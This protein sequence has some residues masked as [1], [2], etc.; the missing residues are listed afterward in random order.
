MKYAQLN[1]DR[2]EEKRLIMKLS[3]EIKQEE[4]HNWIKL[5]FSFSSTKAS[6]SFCSLS[7]ENSINQ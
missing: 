3:D 7:K 6:T 4:K 2:K 5:S 1:D